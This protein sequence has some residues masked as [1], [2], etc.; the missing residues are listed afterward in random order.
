M[1]IY[2]LLAAELDSHIWGSCEEKGEKYG[3]VLL[4]PA[5]SRELTARSRCLLSLAEMAPVSG[6]KVW[7]CDLRAPELSTEAG[8]DVP[9]SQ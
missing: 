5:C 9:H 1:G 3:V 6:E 8:W 7:K 4:L 2:F